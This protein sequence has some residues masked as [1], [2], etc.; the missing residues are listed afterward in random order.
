LKIRKERPK[1]LT[2][3]LRP[4]DIKK[5]AFVLLPSKGIDLT[6]KQVFRQMIFMK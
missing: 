5:A 1:F 2:L 6:K 3:G 4:N